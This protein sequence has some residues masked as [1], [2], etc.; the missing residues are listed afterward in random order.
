MAKINTS[1][2]SNQV[3]PKPFAKKIEVPDNK[4]KVQK[5]QIITPHRRVAASALSTNKQS[6]SVFY[7]K[8][9]QSVF[10]T[11]QQKTKE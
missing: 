1:I 3:S 5:K 8:K 4:Y 7:S 6:Q 2:N 10:G 9:K 11:G